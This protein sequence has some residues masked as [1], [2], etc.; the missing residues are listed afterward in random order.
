MERKEAVKAELD[1]NPSP[2]FYHHFPADKMYYDL[3]STSTELGAVEKSSLGFMD[4]LGIRD[5]P[6]N[7]FTS[8]ILDHHHHHLLQFSTPSCPLEPCG[9]E[10]STHTSASLVLHPDSISVD[11]T[12][13]NSSISSASSTGA[14]AINIDELKSST[15][16]SK[17]AGHEQEEEEEEEEEEE[18]QKTMKQLKVK[19]SE[20]KKKR[21]EREPRF[22]FMTKSEVDH[23]E[24]GYRWRKYGQKAVKNSPFPRSYYRCTNASCNV[25]KRVERCMGD[26]SIVVTTYE[27]KHTHHSQIMPPRGATTSAGGLRPATAFNAAATPFPPQMSPLQSQFVTNLPPFLN[28]GNYSSGNLLNPTSAL[29]TVDH[30]LLQDIVPSLMRKLD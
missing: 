16:R 13:P 4:L 22:A 10:S 3:L 23:L 20:K 12:T 14:A 5:F 27:G 24:D 17:A 30:G 11:P 1:S 29:L 18:H 21:G 15:T 25:K 8:S 28:C 2:L 6:P 7:S 26:P 9:P 19:K